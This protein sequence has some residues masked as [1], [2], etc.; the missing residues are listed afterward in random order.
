M[1]ELLTLKRLARQL[2]LCEEYTKKWNGAVSKRE[3]MDVALDAKGADFIADSHAGGWGLSADFLK[4][5]FGD[6]I[7]GKYVSDAS[8]YTSELYAGYEGEVTQIATLTLM[9]DCKGRFVVPEG[10]ACEVYLSGDC[11]IE[12]ENNGHCAVFAYGERNKL[13][14][15]GN[16]IHVRNIPSGEPHI[17]HSDDEK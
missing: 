13:R 10:R 2:G 9:I 11:D 15:A 3:L 17:N 4:R 14:V 5:E 7:N 12:I 6:Y 8:G 1:N 16:N